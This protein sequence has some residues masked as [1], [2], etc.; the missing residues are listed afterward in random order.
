MLDTGDLR[1][2]PAELRRLVLKGSQADAG[3]AATGAPPALIDAISR[4]FM[5]PHLRT[6]PLASEFVAVHVGKAIN[7][8]LQQVRKETLE[9]FDVVRALMGISLLEPEARELSGKSVRQVK[10]DHVQPY[11]TESGGFDRSVFHVNMASIRS[12]ADL[13]GFRMP[14]PSTAGAPSDD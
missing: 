3:Y 10:A 12:T 13:G 8:F 11:L 7:E 6:A 14:D 9:S 2:S 4:L 1:L 5:I